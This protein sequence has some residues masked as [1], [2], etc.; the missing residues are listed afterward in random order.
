[1]KKFIAIAAIGLCGVVPACAQ[2]YGPGGGCAQAMGVFWN[3]VIRYVANSENVP[4]VSQ[5][6]HEERRLRPSGYSQSSYYTFHTTDFYQQPVRKDKQLFNKRFAEVSNAIKRNHTLKKYTFVVP[7][8]VDLTQLSD[9]DIKYLLNFF[10]QPANVGDF[11]KIYTPYSVEQ[12][13]NGVTEIRLRPYGDSYV[14]TFIL[15]VDSFKKKVFFFLN[16]Y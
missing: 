8:P 13:E 9:K 10:A 14:S 3:N 1:M 7:I 6:R 11:N 12:V 2:N 15:R 4:W 16:E 5:V